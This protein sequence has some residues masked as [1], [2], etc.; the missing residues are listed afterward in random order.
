MLKVVVHSLHAQLGAM[1]Q[2]GE[3]MLQCVHRNGRTL[4]QNVLCEVINDA[5]LLCVDLPLQ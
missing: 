2:T 4:L 3:Y 1:R 5:R